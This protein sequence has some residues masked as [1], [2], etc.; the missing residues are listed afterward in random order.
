M[1]GGI[2]LQQFYRFPGKAGQYPFSW[3]GRKA[4]TCPY[5]EWIS[6]SHPPGPGCD[7]G[8]QLA[9]RWF[10]ESTGMPQEMVTKGFDW[11]IIRFLCHPL[12]TCHM[13]WSSGQGNYCP[14]CHQHHGVQRSD[15]SL[16]KLRM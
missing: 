8:K 5:L 13:T 14:F 6:S 7:F 4:E 10:C 1:A 11:R 12:P 15:L 2:K 3:R 16:N 9:G